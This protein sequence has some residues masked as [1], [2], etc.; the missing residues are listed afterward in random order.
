MGRARAFLTL[1]DLKRDL[2][3]LVQGGAAGHLDFRIMDKQ[4][5]STIVGS[6][7]TKTLCRIKPLD[8]T[9]THYIYSLAQMWAD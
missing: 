9:C 2:L 6:D 1:T 5:L 7:K 4:I 8:C 3:V